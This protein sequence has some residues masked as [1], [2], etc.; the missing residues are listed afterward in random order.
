V[1]IMGTSGNLSHITTIALAVTAL[2]NF[3]LSASPGS[4]TVT[5][6]A[7]GTSTI[8]IAPQNGFTG[9]VN[10]S[11]SGLP[12][13]VTASFSPNPATASSTLT[14][15]A[16]STATAGTVAVTITGTS[17]S[18]TNTTAVSLTVSPVPVADF[19]LSASPSSVTVT[20]GASG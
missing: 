2:P 8:A 17:G 20:Q 18:L 1:T 7:S 13:G 19:G 5:Q 3:G 11:A 9:S 10:L 14:L 16:G 6:G 12:S 15:T 4:M